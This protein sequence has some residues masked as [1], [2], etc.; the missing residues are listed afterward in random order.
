MTTVQRCQ[1]LTAVGRWFNPEVRV[2]IMVS[3]VGS[4]DPLQVRT[5][6]N[7]MVPL[8]GF[9][10]GSPNGDNKCDK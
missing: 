2:D 10:N 9:H 8:V 5:I 6:Q 3:F 1:L 4:T 7:V